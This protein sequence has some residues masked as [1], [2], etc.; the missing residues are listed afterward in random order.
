M[1][2]LNLWPIAEAVVNQTQNLSFALSLS[3]EGPSSL[4]L[5]LGLPPAA[6]R[7]RLGTPFKI[8]TDALMRKSCTH[9]N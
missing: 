1:Y 3:E 4:Q 8:E 5:F 9:R 7:Y 2:T 6:I